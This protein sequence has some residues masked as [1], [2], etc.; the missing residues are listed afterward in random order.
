MAYPQIILRLIE[1]FQKLP[2]VGPKTAERYVF[3]LLK[4]K[5][6]DIYDFAKNLANLR[7]DLTVCLKCQAVSEEK[8]C[9]I[10]SSSSRDKKTLCL[11]ANTQ[12][13]A[14]ME[15]THKYIG[16]YFIL[17]GLINTI[18]NIGPEKLNVKLLIERIESDQIE[19]LI[20]A[21]SPT[22]EGE[23]T[24]LYLKKI[25]EKYNI[26]ITRLAR[27]L[28]AGSSLEYADEITL[29]EALKNRN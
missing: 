19:E 1:H 26:R 5:H 27:G 3:Y 23:T 14:S 17:G 12:E 8:I 20:L 18:D 11:V 6:I 15:N 2:S 9:S 29:A 28:S 24:V 25:L 4:N 13:M 16:L 22:L 21:L 7:K 10:C